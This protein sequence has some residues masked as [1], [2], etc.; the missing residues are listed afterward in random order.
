MTITRKQAL[1]L[2]ET[3]KGQSV[4]CQTIGMGGIPRW[5]VYSIDGVEFLTIDYVAR[6]FIVP[7]NGAQ[8]NDTR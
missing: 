4:T 1:A 2:I 8:K 7:N 3:K 6:V 5:Q